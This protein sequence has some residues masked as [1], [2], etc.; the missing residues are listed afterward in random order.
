MVEVVGEERLRRCRCCGRCLCC[1][2]GRLGGVL[3]DQSVEVF[4]VVD[5]VFPLAATF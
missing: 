1:L 5:L 3:V 4:L 2:L